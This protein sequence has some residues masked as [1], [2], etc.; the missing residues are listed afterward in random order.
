[1]EN[2]NKKLGEVTSNDRVTIRVRGFNRVRDRD[3][4]RTG[5]EHVILI[6][7]LPPSPNGRVEKSPS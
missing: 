1:M 7:N 5:G 3:R 6:E 2:N 4:V